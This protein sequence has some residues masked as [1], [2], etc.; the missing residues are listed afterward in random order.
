[1]EATDEKVLKELQRYAQAYFAAIVA[2]HKNLPAGKYSAKDIAG[3]KV[4][5][6]FAGEVGEEF[7]REIE[8]TAGAF[9]C[10][11]AYHS[12]FEM[13][14]R[15]E[16][17]C[18]PGKSRAVFEIAGVEEVSASVLLNEKTV[19][20]KWR[21]KRM[22]LVRLTGGWLV[23]KTAY[24][25][26]CSTYRNAVREAA[27]YYELNG[28]VFDSTSKI[29]WFHG[30]TPEEMCE[31]LGKRAEMDAAQV[32]EVLKKHQTSEYSTEQSCEYAAEVLRRVDTSAAEDAKAKD[33]DS[34]A[35]SPKRAAG[36]VSDVSADNSS[37]EDANAVTTAENAPVVAV[38]H[39]LAPDGIHSE[40][41]EMRL[42][43][44]TAGVWYA[45]DGKQAR[46][47]YEQNGVFWDA[48]FSREI[49]MLKDAAVVTWLARKRARAV[50]A[51]FSGEWVGMHEAKIIGLIKSAAAASSSDKV[52]DN[53]N[54]KVNGNAAAAETACNADNCGG[55]PSDCDKAS[56]KQSDNV[57]DKVSDKVNGKENPSANAC[58]AAAC[59]GC[60]TAS[61]K[62]SDKVNDKERGKEN[63]KV[64][65]KQ[66]TKSC[67]PHAK[68]RKP[69]LAAYWRQGGIIPYPRGKEPPHGKFAASW[70][71]PVWCAGYSD[72]HKHA[73]STGPPGIAAHNPG[74]II[75]FKP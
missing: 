33:A 67:E 10:R 20:G 40:E 60:S 29:S 38:C 25:Q 75:I 12:I 7:N 63:G 41:T 39:T 2:T 6:Y 44:V 43:R 52:N 36:G 1:M 48:F 68:A 27:L 59:G 37:T 17:M 13:L 5:K 34:A 22:T 24:R 74:K 57:S 45:E 58:N 16:A 49:E 73:R 62:H 11:V 8:I 64:F 35:A 28:V 72:L 19:T 42:H 3:G 50:D 47:F 56:G 55:V 4:I 23:T 54:N 65:G 26:A 69:P 51:L 31:C 9:H 18:K 15:W 14:A 32:A 21:E 66:T 53:A 71:R 30:K 61:D 70:A 46:I